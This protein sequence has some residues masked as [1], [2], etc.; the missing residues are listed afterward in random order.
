MR[1]REESGERRVGEPGGV[2]QGM[3]YPSCRPAARIHWSKV[4]FYPSCYP[5]CRRPE[6]VLSAERD[7][8]KAEAGGTERGNWQA[9]RRADGKTTQAWSDRLYRTG[10]GALV[11]NSGSILSAMG[12][13]RAKPAA[14]IAGTALIR[15][16]GSDDHAAAPKS[17]RIVRECRTKNR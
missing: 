10:D 1:R 11:M 3:V 5:S 17:E 16:P 15:N 8:G 9:G 6:P 7:G 2:A 12:M 4:S 14:A 13:L